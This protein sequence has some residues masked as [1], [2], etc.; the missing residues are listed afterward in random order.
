MDNSKRYKTNRYYNV[1]KFSYIDGNTVKKT[2]TVQPATIQTEEDVRLRRKE[3]QKKQQQINRANRSNFIYTIGV[4][5]VVATM[6]YICYQY[7]D[8]QTSVKSSASEVAVLE[9]KYESLKETNDEFETEINASINLDDVFSVA[10]NELGMTYPNKNQVIN[11]KS[12]ESEY[13]RQ[14][15]DIPDSN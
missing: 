6:F 9:A 12:L 2:A 14:F 8:L 15:K 1:N 5:L 3:K 7:L 4:S 13:V 11:Y 10:V